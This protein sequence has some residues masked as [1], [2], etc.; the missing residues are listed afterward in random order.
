MC[1][2]ESGI[3]KNKA[4]YINDEDGLLWCGKCHTPKQCRI[5]MLGRIYTPY[6]LCKCGQERLAE[7]KAEREQQERFAEGQRLKTVSGMSTALLQNRFEGYRVTAENQKAYALCRRYAERFEKMPKKNQ[8]LL[9]WGGVGTG[10]T[11]SAAC[12]ANALLDRGISVVMTSF[13]QI[14]GKGK[15]FDVDSETADRLNRAKV[16]I[17]DDLGAERNTDFALERVYSIIDSRY[18]AG[19]PMILTTNLDLSEMQ[20][21]TDIRYKRVYERILEVCYPVRFAGNS[22]RKAEAAN[23]F[24]EMEEFLK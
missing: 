24:R 22:L 13:A 5:T 12:I 18:A 16:L 2:A 4:D 6:C 9:L 11:F 19:K 17:I 21:C 23:R 14:L 7:E 20:M 10:K 3:P 8:G 15:G 1:K